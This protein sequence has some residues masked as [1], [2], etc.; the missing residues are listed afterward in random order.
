MQS[1]FVVDAAAAD[2]AEEGTLTAEDVE[3]LLDCLA[4]IEKL[5][6]AMYETLSGQG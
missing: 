1:K 6:D 4:G 3:N 2:S 5:L